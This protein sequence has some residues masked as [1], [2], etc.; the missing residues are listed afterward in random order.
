M[1]AGPTQ[2]VRSLLQHR[3]DVPLLA[4]GLG[5]DR[6]ALGVDVDLVGRPLPFGPRGGADRLADVLDAQPVLPAELPLHLLEHR[7]G[8][9]DLVALAGEAQLVVAADDA[10]AE[11]LADHPQVPVGRPEQGQLLVRLF[12][13][14]AEVHVS[15][16]CFM[17]SLSSQASHGWGL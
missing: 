12:E 17:W 4:L 2:N 10:D 3:L 9:A 1:P 6:V 14:D 8:L 13:G 5:L 15:M 11:R 7:R 16:C